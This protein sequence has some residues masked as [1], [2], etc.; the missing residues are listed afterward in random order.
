MLCANALQHLPTP[1]LR[2]RVIGELNRVARI[3]GRIVITT[4]N[5]SE[6]K[7]KMGWR[8]EMENIGSFSG[9]VQYIYRFESEE[10]KEFLSEIMMVESVTGVG[11]SIPCPFRLKRTGVYYA[12]DWT[13]GQFRRCAPY[14]HMLLGRCI[15]R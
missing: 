11:F 3:G 13:L 14:G 8:K 9:P 4:H 1:S 6:G 7:K 5:Y 10:F 12:M 15:A 2:S